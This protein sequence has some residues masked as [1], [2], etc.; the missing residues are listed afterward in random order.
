MNICITE[1]CDNE[2]TH[3]GGL[4]SKCSAE[5]RLRFTP[6]SISAG[7]SE[8]QRKLEEYNEKQK[9]ALSERR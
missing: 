3:G 6:E 8:F 1:N 9:K 4:C 2:T 5:S 7:R